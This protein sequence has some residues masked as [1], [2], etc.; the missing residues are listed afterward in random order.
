ML[1]VTSWSEELKQLVFS[2]CL[3]NMLKNNLYYKII[4]LQEDAQ[5]LT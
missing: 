3:R 4:T 5:L 1:N 2:I